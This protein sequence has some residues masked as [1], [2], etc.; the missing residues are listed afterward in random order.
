M[1]TLTHALLVCVA[2]SWT[3]ACDPKNDGDDPHVADESELEEDETEGDE[4]PDEDPA[5]EACEAQRM[6]RSCGDDGTATQWCDWSSEHDALA[7][8]PCLVTTECRPGD[9][10][11]CFPGEDDDGW[12]DLSRGCFLDEGVPRW[13]EEGCNTP[14]VLS[15]GGDPV[16]FSASS[17]TFDITGAGACITTDWPD[18]QTPWL[19]IDLDG[20]GSI[21]GGHELFG[22][23]TVLGSG[24]H[25]RHGFAALASLDT[26]GD[27]RI[28]PNDERF[29]DLVLWSDHDGDR[30]STP[31]ELE[32]LSVRGVTSISL[33]YEDGR[34][35]DERGNCLRQR[36]TVE[37]A[38]GSAQPHAEVIDVHMACQ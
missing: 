14:L 26:D 15:F 17:A 9:S 12:G 34:S 3:T 19:A 18:A 28:T 21:D 25:A 37:L 5:F 33:T 11:L 6:E 8:G 7:W 38:P 10:Q 22:T 16:Q 13:D 30:R 23:G 1:K 32:P 24:R 20:N 29:D 35:C 31:W 2:A 36:A 27:G 4:D